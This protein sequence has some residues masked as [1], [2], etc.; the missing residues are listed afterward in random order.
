MN[1][2]LKL[3]AAIILLA[4]TMS[5]TVEKTEEGELPEVEVNTESGKLPKYK[6]DWANVKVSTRTKTIE[7]PKVVIV[8]EKK[9]VEVPYIEFNGPDGDATKV[10]E[11]TIRMEVEVDDESHDLEIKQIYANDDALYVVAELTPTGTDLQ[12]ETVRI[13][14]Q[15]VINAPKSDIEYLV[16]GKRPDGFFNTQYEFIDSKEELVNELDG[17]KMIFE[18]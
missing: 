6:V 17:A 15:V 2:I 18:K 14:D 3:I 16:I 13:S 7:V 1:T 5:C 11:R 10:R 12:G 4:F 8:K 9:Q